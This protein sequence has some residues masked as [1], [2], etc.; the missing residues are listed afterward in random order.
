MKQTGYLIKVFLTI[1]II[2]FLVANPGFAIPANVPA[3][4]SSTGVTGYRMNQFTGNT[5][6]E[7]P[8]QVPAGINGFEPKLTLRY[9]TNTQLSWLGQ[10]WDLALGRIT[11][12]NRTR[13]I[14]FTDSDIFVL[15][16]ESEGLHDELLN[17]SGPN[18][19]TLYKRRDFQITKNGDAGWVVKDGKGTT[20]EFF[21]Q[22]RGVGTG[23]IWGWNLS[24]MIDSHGNTI[25]ITYDLSAAQLSGIYNL[26]RIDYAGRSIV[27]NTE[28]RD[29]EYYP[30]F[31]KRG[32]S[33]MTKALASLQM[34]PTNTQYQFH[35]I[36]P[37][38]LYHVVLDSVDWIGSD[39][40]TRRMAAMT[41]QNGAA[42][43]NFQSPVNFSAN[44]P[45]GSMEDN[46]WV[47]ITDVNG[48]G[49]PDIYRNYDQG[50]VQ[51]ALGTGN[52]WNNINLT[53]IPGADF[54][55][56]FSETVLADIN[57]D[58][59]IDSVRANPSTGWRFSLGTGSSW[60]P[61]VL[62]NRPVPCLFNT[63]NAC[64]M[65]D[66]NGD[67]KDDIYRTLANDNIPNE[68]EIAKH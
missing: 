34:L 15:E 16:L 25:N 68:I 48:D 52:N 62:Q 54:L 30:K 11:R 66:I 37:N 61:V 58:G 19:S 63:L 28:N 6:Y 67:G 44:L 29:L 39:G 49:I 56:G 35:Y 32:A 3:N 17:V 38:G 33:Q 53:N 1:P 47:T 57:G 46:Q 8:L 7:I 55:W 51:Y 21:Q 65:L 59:F 31:Q 4:I 5:S 23:L 14:T 60:N 42:A 9:N 41:Y 64:I 27:F 20:Y 10:G 40:Q 36:R 2:L 50:V 12:S 45:F 24:R 13:A 22:D 43:A 26:S 18:Y